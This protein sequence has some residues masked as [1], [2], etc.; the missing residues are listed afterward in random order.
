MAHE[1]GLKF[2]EV[3]VTKLNPEAAKILAEAVR[4]GA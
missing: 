2:K 3:E 4:I 1:L